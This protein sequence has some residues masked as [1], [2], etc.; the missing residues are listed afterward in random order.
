MNDESGVCAVQVQVCGVPELRGLAASQAQCLRVMDSATS[1]LP[2][3]STA[4][5]DSSTVHL[6]LRSY[7]T[8]VLS[9][10]CEVSVLG[11]MQTDNPVAVMHEQR[12]GA[13]MS[14]GFVLISTLHAMVSFRFFHI[15]RAVTVFSYCEN[16]LH[17]C[18][19]PRLLHE[20]RP[21]EL[22]CCDIFTR[23]RSAKSVP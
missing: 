5:T 19:L 4:A 16:Q 8:A 22:C 9:Y 3:Y 15:A 6:T 2:S 23:T 10:M 14:G 11:L 21:G 20:V 18:Q 17:A 13:V 12:L 1:A 7:H